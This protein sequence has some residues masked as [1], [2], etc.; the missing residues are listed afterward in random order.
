MTTTKNLACTAGSTM[1]TASKQEERK[2]GKIG[3]WE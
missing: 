3:D 2:G 1:T